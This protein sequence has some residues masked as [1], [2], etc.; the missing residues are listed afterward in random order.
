MT[1]EVS[2][3]TALFTRMA[4]L[5]L[6]PAMPV[7]WPNVDFSPVLSG[8]LMVTHLANGARRAFIGSAGHHQR[9]GILQVSVFAPLNK[10][11]SPATEIAGK[12]AEHFP[13]DLKLPSGDVSV[14][15]TKAPDIMQ[16]MRNDSF[17]HVPV[18]VSYECW[19]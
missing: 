14:R 8:Y 3:E 19:A 17:W 7:A 2:I 12:V 15:I 16:A 5:V 1:I 10:G 9:L 13:C 4:A 11:A 6:S 18:R